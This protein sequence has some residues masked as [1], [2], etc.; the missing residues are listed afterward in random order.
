MIDL[1]RTLQHS[2]R[3]ARIE[4]DRRR[5]RQFQRAR[6]EKEKRDDLKEAEDVSA[7]GLAAAVALSPPAPPER[8]EAFETQ[9]T[10]FDIAVVKALMQNQEA[11]D[12]V[13]ARIELLLARA[14]VLPDGRR[15]FRTEDGTQ[16]F[17]EFGELVS[18]EIIEPDEISATAPTWEEFNANGATP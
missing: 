5:R 12:A 7:T 17:D 14:H 16:V 1:A 4:A 6:E 15:V 3:H 2:N 13:L 8:I 11:M 18:P 9:L 10:E